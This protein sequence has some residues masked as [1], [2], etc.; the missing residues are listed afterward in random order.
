MSRCRRPI[1]HSGSRSAAAS[2]GSALAARRSRT[3]RELY[4]RLMDEY[5]CDVLV[6]RPDYYLFGACRTADLPAMLADLRA[7][8]T[9]G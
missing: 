6:K 1:A 9:G 2:C 8:L 5:G 3:A 7:Q 4:T